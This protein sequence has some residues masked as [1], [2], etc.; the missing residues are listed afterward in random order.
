M[1]DIAGAAERGRRQRTPFSSKI[2]EAASVVTISEFSAGEIV[3]WLGVPRERLVLAAPGAPAWRVKQDAA[4]REPLVL[5]VGSLFA[6]R[7]IPE[8]IDGFAP[9]TQ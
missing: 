1:P 9:L 4:R 3:R 7:H 8:L 6:R 2:T 5:Y